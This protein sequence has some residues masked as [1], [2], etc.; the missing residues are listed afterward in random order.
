MAVDTEDKRRHA[1]GVK[2]PKPDGDI[3]QADRQQVA[4]VYPGILADEAAGLVTPASRKVIIAAES[5][6]VIIAAES[7]TMIIAAENR[8]VTIL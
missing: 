6:T 4:G 1:V 3:D 8:T 2:I 7:R 5:R